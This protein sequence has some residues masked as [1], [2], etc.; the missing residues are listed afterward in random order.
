MTN[1]RI[2]TA[3]KALRRMICQVASPLVDGVVLT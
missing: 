1:S 2:L 3:L